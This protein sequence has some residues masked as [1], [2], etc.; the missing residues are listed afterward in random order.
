[1]SVSY[2]EGTPV[3]PVR[4]AMPEPHLGAGPVLRLPRP[5]LNTKLRA[6]NQ[7]LSPERI[8]ADDSADISLGVSEPGTVLNRHNP[9]ALSSSRLHAIPLQPPKSET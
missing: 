3:G 4:A 2:D 1:M 9:R 5:Y 7:V 6:L 8:R